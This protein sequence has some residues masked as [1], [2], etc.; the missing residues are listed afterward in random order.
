MKKTSAILII[1]ISLF[2]ISCSVDYHLNKAIKKGYSCDTVS[3]TITITSVDSIPFIVRDSI[4]WE[5]I[6]TKKDTIIAYKTSY[7]PKTRYE[8]RFDNKRFADSLK[9][10][11]K[12]YEIQIKM[13]RDSSST[14]IKIEKQKTK[15]I[16]YE[17]KKGF[18]LFIIGVLTGIILT[19]I[20]KYAINQALKKFT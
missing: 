3:D 1:I 9:A 18:N 13:N 14:A 8:I 4:V 10:I 12:M 15:Q 2:A 20:S 11:R 6:I 19:L 7:V 5:K 17:N 16:K